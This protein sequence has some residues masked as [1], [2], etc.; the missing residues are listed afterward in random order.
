ME[1][2]AR[3]AVRG[4]ARAAI[5]ARLGIAPC[6][7]HQ[8]GRRQKTKNRRLGIATLTARPPPMGH[9]WAGCF[10]PIPIWMN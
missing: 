9:R 7:L 1:G 4:R 6:L 8:D 2:R 5:E 3:A 10:W